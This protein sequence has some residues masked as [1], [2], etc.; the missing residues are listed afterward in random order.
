[1]SFDD[2]SSCRPLDLGRAI[3]GGG[4][5]KLYRA[6]DVACERAD[7]APAKV[8]LQAGQTSEDE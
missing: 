6:G 8:E 4:S 5:R 7:A 3:D 2:G 1:V